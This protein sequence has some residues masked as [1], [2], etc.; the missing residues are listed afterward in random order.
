M[1]APLSTAG[2]V[3]A[4]KRHFPRDPVD[5]DMARRVI[6]ALADLPVEA[7]AAG[8]DDLIRTRVFPS[9]PLVAE[10]RLA[11]VQH[12]ADFPSDSMA[13]EQIEARIAWAKQDEDVRADPP[14][15][16]GLVREALDH[17]GGWHAFRAADEPA[18]VRGQF[19]RLYR[20]LRAEALLDLQR[21]RPW[22][23]AAATRKEL[24]T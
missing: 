9:F 14:V 21:G 15:V 6:D 24:T 20:D 10:I 23:L 16:H 7:L 8:A 11:A 12:L 2:I 18:V 3:A 5:T 22:A 4:L 1:D 13:L 19:L 17:V